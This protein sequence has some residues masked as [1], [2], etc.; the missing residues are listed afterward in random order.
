MLKANS[1][2]VSPP[3]RCLSATNT[4]SSGKKEEDEREE[5]ML[6]SMMKRALMVISKT[7][8]G[9]GEE[10]EEREAVSHLGAFVRRNSNGVE[11]GFKVSG[12]DAKYYPPMSDQL[13]ANKIEC[14][15]GFDK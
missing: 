6:L 1:P 10:E 2:I 3:I 15:K 5:K 13:E 8:G 12:C 7:F 4:T 11:L 14:I 9:E